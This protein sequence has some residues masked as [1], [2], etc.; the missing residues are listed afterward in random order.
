MVVLRLVLTLLEVTFA[1]VALALSYQV[2]DIDVMVSHIV[3]SP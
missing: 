2:I 1:P 3:E